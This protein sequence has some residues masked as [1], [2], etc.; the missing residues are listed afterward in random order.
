MVPRPRI[1]SRFQLLGH[2]G[3]CLLAR[4][5]SNDH[6]GI[7]VVNPGRKCFGPAAKAIRGGPKDLSLHWSIRYSLASSTEMYSEAILAN[8][9]QEVGRFSSLG[10]HPHRESSLLLPQAAEYF[11][12]SRRDIPL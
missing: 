4:S 3:T 11:Q 12:R 10:F 6:E 2:T 9:Y 7:R 1:Q 5:L 8:R